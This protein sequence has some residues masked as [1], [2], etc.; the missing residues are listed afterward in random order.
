MS[1]APRSQS[2]TQATPNLTGDILL[3][4]GTNELEVL[5][6]SLRAGASDSPGTASASGHFG[7]NVAKV[8][9]VIRAQ[10][11]VAAPGQHPSV[12]GMF[13]IR[14]S[15]IPVIDLAKHLG[16]RTGQR[17]ADA[18]TQRII[19]T[20][21]NGLRAGF[22][23]DGVDQIHRMS[24]QRVRPSPA[25]AGL[26]AHG[27][28]QL[29]AHAVSSTTGIVEIKDHL[30]QMIDF[31]SVAD[32]ILMQDKLKVQNVANDLGVD[33]AAKRVVIAEDSPF[34][35]SII[36]RVFRAS[37]YSQLKV[38][39]NGEAAWLAIQ[40]AGE[41]GT[42]L[43]CVVSDIEMPRMDGLHLCKRIKQHAALKGVPV[44]L[45]SSLISQ[46]NLNKGQAVGADLQIAKPEL[47][48]MVRLVDRAV[49]GGLRR[50]A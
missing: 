47:A 28:T 43:D 12:V 48:E 35:R 32:A 33:R 5:V 16:L 13:N 44:I 34:M 19:I 36:E 37:G 9:E 14:G 15:V 29:S 17:A 6:F 2:I 11:T 21:F 45:F 27:S 26:A 50:D 39:D 46:D 49:S 22:L 40:H 23:V 25:L 1:A 38:F 42:P 3:E 18:A 31:E 7:V 8:R 24:W 10:Q 20:E 41:T 30:V 4:A